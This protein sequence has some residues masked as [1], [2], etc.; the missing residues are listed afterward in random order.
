MYLM[1]L[2]ISALITAGLTILLHLLDRRGKLDKIKNPWIRQLLIGI[3]FGLAAIYATEFGSVQIGGAALNARDA[4]PLCAG[5]FFGGFAGIVAGVI[6][7]VERF[8]CVYWGGAAFTQLA[9]SIACIFAGL[10]SAFL[11]KFIFNNKRPNPYYCVIIA[12]I[13]ETIHMFL[14]FVTNEKDLDVAFDF[15]QKCSPPMILTNILAL[16]L[17]FFTIEFIDRGFAMFKRHNRPI[18]SHLQIGLLMLVVVSAALTVYITIVV[19][20]RIAEKST[21]RVFAAN[22]KAAAAQIDNLYLTGQIDD[23]K[24]VASS[25][26][27]GYSVGETGELWTTNMDMV[28][29]NTEFD[30]ED[31]TYML[32]GVPQLTLVKTEFE[33]EGYY[34]SYLVRSGYCLVA[35]MMADDALYLTNVSI[36]ITILLEILVYAVLF[37]FITLEMKQLV[38]EKMNEVN[39]NLEA[40]TAGE[41][42]RVVNVRSSSEFEMLSDSIN[43]MVNRLTE[44]IEEA[45]NRV[46]KELEIARSIQ[47]SSLTQEFDLSPAVDVFAKTRP[48]K[49]VGGDF[50]DAYK[51]DATHVVF[52]IAD[53]S[54]KGIPAAMFMMRARTTIKS[55]A[56]TGLPIDE[57]F[58][59]VNGRLCHNNVNEMFITAWMGILDL[60]TGGVIFVNAGHN[61]PIIKRNGTYTYLETKRNL[62]LAAMDGYKYRSET[63][64]IQPGDEIFL[65]TDGVTEAININEELY[66]EDRLM[67]YIRETDHDISAENLCEGVYKSVDDYA[68]EGV[69]QFDDITVLSLKYLKSV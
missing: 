53:V 5:L 65:Y 4:A 22:L 48:A 54:G 60:T 18:L 13:S 40:I 55:L 51:L 7:G 28:V 30:G 2:I 50:Y 38:T 57:V 6:G 1:K 62:V 52:L 56:Q 12:L 9:C 43:A 26:C 11:R 23:V 21:E 58:T 17:A 63:L 68:G 29:Y 16:F 27:Y 35:S 36:Y 66:G 15:V 69:E 41:L 49:E 44:L 24:D 64:S 59:Q 61:P 8:F 45:K 32:A 14:I 37:L 10:F 19:Q 34:V 42:D 3:L 47:L 33:G 39:D 67:V 31:L 25:V 20:T 46:A